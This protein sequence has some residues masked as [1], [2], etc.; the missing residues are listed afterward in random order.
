MVSINKSIEIIT[1][2]L[3]GHGLMSFPVYSDFFIDYK[4]MNSKLFSIK[5]L[6]RN[7]LDL[8][9]IFMR[10][11]EHSYLQ[12]NQILKSQIKTMMK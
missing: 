6:K 3:G 4:G 1:I 8:F 12:R 11:H 5:T 10:F 2:C 7:R 9:K